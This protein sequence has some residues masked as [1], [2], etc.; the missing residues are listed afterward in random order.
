MKKVTLSLLGIASG[1]VVWSPG[2]SWGGDSE[3]MQLLST[4]KC[5][6]CDLRRANLVHADLSGADLEGADL[7]GAN[8]SQAN[9]RQANLNQANLRGTSLFGADLS[10]V[11]ALMTTFSGADLREANLEASIISNESLNGAH[12][13][14]AR[15]IPAGAID[16]ARIHNQGVSEYERGQYALAENKFNE[17]IKIKPQAIES[18]LGRGFSRAKMEKTQAAV[19]DLSYAAQ[20][21][22]ASGEKSNSLLIRQ[23]AANVESGAIGQSEN[24]PLVKAASGVENALRSLAPLALKFL[25][26]G[27]L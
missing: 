19:S 3:V 22:E 18:W 15:N 24:K 14:G 9:L 13:E 27:M 17:A 5:R 1:F 21:A 11:T 2:L 12:I 26:K 8:L 16:H 4:G 25:G 10:E 20:L 7:G 23:L 6:G